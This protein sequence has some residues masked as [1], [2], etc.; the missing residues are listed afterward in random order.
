MHVTS[1]LYT[2]FSIERLIH[3]LIMQINQTVLNR[4]LKKALCRTALASN[5]VEA[6]EAVK[7]AIEDP[8]DVILMGKHT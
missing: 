4:Q 5:G 7:A 2:S 1:I 6:L 3:H 8:F